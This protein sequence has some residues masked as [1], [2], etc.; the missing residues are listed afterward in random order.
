MFQRST[1]AQTEHT[2]QTGGALQRDLEYSVSKLD[3]ADS[4]IQLYIYDFPNGP[5]MTSRSC[6]GGGGANQKSKTIS[7]IL[8]IRGYQLLQMRERIIENE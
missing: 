5:Y 2:T 3:R 1:R 8:P 7:V 4:F 6:G